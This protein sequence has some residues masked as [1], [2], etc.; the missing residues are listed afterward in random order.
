MQIKNT[1]ITLFCR[2]TERFKQHGL[3]TTTPSP[4]TPATTGPMKKVLDLQ[5]SPP[6]KITKPRQFMLP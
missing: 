5:V 2:F 4:F 6:L 1:K 3:S